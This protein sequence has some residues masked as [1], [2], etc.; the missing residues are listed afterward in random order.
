ML[1]YLIIAGIIYVVYSELNSK[2]K[3]IKDLH[4]TWCTREL[5]NSNMC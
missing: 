4:N 2:V 1:G 5:Q 3:A